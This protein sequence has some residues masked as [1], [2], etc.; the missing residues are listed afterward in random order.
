MGDLEAIK[1]KLAAAALLA[2]LAL[3]AGCGSA[4]DSTTTTSA[5]DTTT[6]AAEKPKQGK[7]RA[8]DPCTP[9][10]AAGPIEDPPRRSE[11]GKPVPIEVGKTKL[12]LEV[13][14]TALPDSIPIRFGERPPFKREGAMLVALTYR[15]ENKGPDEVKPSEN[16]NAQLLLRVSG[17]LYPYAAELPCGIPITASWALDQGGANPALPVEPGDEAT[18]AVVFVIPKQEPGTQL[19]L[20]VPEQVG[21]GLRPAA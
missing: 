4:G 9:R 15:L 10:R 19:S 5:G 6:A 7:K 14:R 21:I 16:V 1:T 11:Q 2:V 8:H 18:T 13:E 12:T 20:V 17:A 3:A